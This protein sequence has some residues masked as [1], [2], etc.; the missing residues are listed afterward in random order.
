MCGNYLST[1]KEIDEII[2][3]CIPENTFTSKEQLE[4]KMTEF[5]VI[6]ENSR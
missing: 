6:Y 3:S 4:K 2:K 5:F 1:D